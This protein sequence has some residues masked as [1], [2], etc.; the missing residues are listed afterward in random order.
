MPARPLITLHA[1]MAPAVTEAIMQ[2]VT[3]MLSRWDFKWWFVTDRLPDLVLMVD[4]PK[5]WHDRAPTQRELE[6]FDKLWADGK[7]EEARALARTGLP[8]A[9]R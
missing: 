3:E 1:P 4:T 5:Q 2:P 6:A 8:E 9:E 7:V